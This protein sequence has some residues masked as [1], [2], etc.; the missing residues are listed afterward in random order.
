MFKRHDLEVELEIPLSMKTSLER[1]DADRID[2]ADGNVLSIALEVE[3]GH[4]Y[5]IIAP[6]ANY[7]PSAPTTMLVQAPFSDF[8]TGKDSRA[9]RSRRS[10]W[11]ISRKSPCGN[12]STPPAATPPRCI[13]CTRSR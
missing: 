5:V 11:A 7:D 12:G 4:D 3:R 9:E 10:K 6:G 2:I 1:F 8:R 13:S